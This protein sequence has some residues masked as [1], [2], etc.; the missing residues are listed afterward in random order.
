MITS[1]TTSPLA[2]SNIAAVLYC[3][4]GAYD[5]LILVYDVEEDGSTG[6]QPISASVVV[7]EEPDNFTCPLPLGQPLKHWL[8][9][10]TLAFYTII[11]LSHSTSAVESDSTIS[12]G[13][14]AH[15]ELEWI[16][17][18]LLQMQLLE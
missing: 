7:E 3:C 15:T 12:G 2:W 18:F 9:I 16:V 5:D 8:P 13:M 14:L 6:S 11:I 4:R 10:Y 17:I 1:T